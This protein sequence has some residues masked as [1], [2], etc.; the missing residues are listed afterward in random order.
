MEPSPSGMV[1]PVIEMYVARE[2]CAS[3][4]GTRQDLSSSEIERSSRMAARV[5][6]DRCRYHYGMGI[7]PSSYTVVLGAES[8]AT[9]LLKARFGLFN[10]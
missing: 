4:R 9:G 3:S 10:S 1:R 8:L 6:H 2:I 5:S 7:H